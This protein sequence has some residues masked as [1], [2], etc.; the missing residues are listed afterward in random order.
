MRQLGVAIN[1]ALTGPVKALAE[2]EGLGN[3]SDSR[4]DECELVIEGRGFAG[5]R[6]PEAVLDCG[7]SGTTA[8]LLTGLLAGRP[9][10]SQLTGDQSLK[11][12]PFK[13]VCQPLGQ[14]G[15]EFSGDMLPFTVQGRALGGIDYISPRASAQVKSAVL[16]AGLQSDG[17]VSITEPHKSRDHTERM[18][19]AMGCGLEGTLLP[20][21][22]WKIV[23][24]EERRPVRLAPLETSVPGDFSARCIFPGRSK[25]RVR[26]QGADRECG[27]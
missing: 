26:L 17:G 15:A 12:R 5:L 6:A 24:D 2:A 18:L 3:F 11:R 9:F 14:M 23:L 7:N 1:G 27:L 22:G 25:Y 20:E 13:R 4:S 21:G 19:Q 16:L 10:A 8:R